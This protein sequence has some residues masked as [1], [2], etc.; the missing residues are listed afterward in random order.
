MSVE[1]PAHTKFFTLEAA[2][3]T[4]PLVRAIVTD[5]SRLSRDVVERRE[6]LSLLRGSRETRPGD[7]Y[8][9]E[10]AQ[11]EDELEKDRGELQGYIDELRQL[12]VEPKNG[13]EGLVDFP[14]LME[15]RVVYLCWRLGE[16]EVLFWHEIEAGFAG[17]QA[18]VAG[19]VAEGDS[20]DPAPDD[21]SNAGD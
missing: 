3:A 5:L 19:I 15:G 4:L 20:P 17:R 13:L 21:A 12:G 2:N 14:C 10:L 7:P 9:A 8:S 11:I 18:L 1:L 16:P 6:R